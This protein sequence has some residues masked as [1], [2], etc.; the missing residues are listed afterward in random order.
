MEQVHAEDLSYLPMLLHFCDRWH[1]EGQSVVLHERGV[2]PLF[3]TMPQH[4][5]LVPVTL[6]LGPGFL[7]TSPAWSRSSRRAR[8]TSSL[9]LWPPAGTVTGRCWVL[10]MFLLLMLL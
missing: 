5:Q 6:T 9:G 3:I 1:L 10:P 4:S 7:S 8:S 2:M